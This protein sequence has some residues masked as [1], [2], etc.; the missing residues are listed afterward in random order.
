MLHLP[1]WYTPE[2]VFRRSQ[3]F[4]AEPHHHAMNPKPEPSSANDDEFADAGRLGD[5]GGDDAELVSA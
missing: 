4:L 1:P 2:G 3:H 5:V